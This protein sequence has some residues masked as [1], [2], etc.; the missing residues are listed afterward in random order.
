MGDPTFV[1][2]LLYIASNRPDIYLKLDENIFALILLFFFFLGGSFC[3]S[4]SWMSHHDLPSYPL[5]YPLHYWNKTRE[6]KKT[7]DD[8]D[9]SGLFFYNPFCNVYTT[10]Q[11][12]AISTSSNQFFLSS[13]TELVIRKV[14]FQMEV[15]HCKCRMIFCLL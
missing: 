14:P 11:S 2:S 15:N 5:C 7:G 3:A 9:I 12:P 6:E 4:A 1:V 13:L 10:L 8:C